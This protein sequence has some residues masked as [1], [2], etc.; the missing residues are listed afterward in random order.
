MSEFLEPL[1]RTDWSTPN[2]LPSCLC[3]LNIFSF[4]WEGLYY[5]DIKGIKCGPSNI[6]TA[7]KNEIQ[8]FKS[9][10]N[11]F[12]FTSSCTSKKV[13]SKKYLGIQLQKGV[14]QSVRHRGSKNSDISRL[15]KFR[16]CIR[17]GS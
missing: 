14:F 15:Q 12:D 9:F 3:R 16:H 2:G 11:H 7:L 5:I 13:I 10:T 6:V 4:F 17:L 1:C 8:A